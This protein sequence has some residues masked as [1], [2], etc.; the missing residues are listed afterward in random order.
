MEQLKT[1][2]LNHFF[3]TSIVLSVNA[4]YCTTD[5][6]TVRSLTA[7]LEGSALVVTFCFRM[8]VSVF[9]LV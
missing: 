8:P 5:C 6:T 3:M 1:S 9:H 7:V 4:M 2:D